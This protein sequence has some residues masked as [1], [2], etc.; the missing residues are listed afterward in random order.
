MGN[1]AGIEASA[2]YYSSDLR[3]IGVYSDFLFREDSNNNQVSA[4]I[5]FGV[6]GLGVDMGYYRDMN[7]NSGFLVRP[8]V[9][10]MGFMP[11]VRFG[12][13]DDTYIEYGCLFKYPLD[14]RHPW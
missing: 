6:L 9:W 12:I 4:G 8:F 11:Y 5:E 2:C 1:H 10:I 3:F 14:F 7:N 13:K